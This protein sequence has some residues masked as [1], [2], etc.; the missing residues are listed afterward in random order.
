MPSSRLLLVLVLVAVLA[1]TSLVVLSVDSPDD[2]ERY[3]ELYVLPFSEQETETFGEFPARIAVNESID[4]VLGVEN[5]EHTRVEYTLVVL[6]QRTE[7]Q[8]E[9][10]TVVEANVRRRFD[11]SLPRNESWR[12]QYT[13]TP[14]SQGTSVRVAFLLYKGAP[15]TEPSIE[16]AYRETHFWV[17]VGTNR[18]SDRSTLPVSP[19][20]QRQSGSDENNR[21][22][23]RAVIHE[24]PRK[25]PI[26]R[27]LDLDP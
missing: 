10:R 12:T 25:R 11:F 13:Y 15:P 18:S 8:D 16:S 6:E 17:D 4:V 22:L 27:L 19:A 24:D 2:T 14:E 20:D 23:T 5:D 7:L 21:R 1:S 3:T 9:E 26:C